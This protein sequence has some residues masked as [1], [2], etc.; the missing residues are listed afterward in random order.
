M[1]QRNLVLF[2]FQ[3]GA[4]GEMSFN[5]TTMSRPGVGSA[6]GGYAGANDMA[7]NGLSANQN[8]VSLNN[9]FLSSII[10]KSATITSESTVHRVV[11]LHL[12]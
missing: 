9:T 4:R 12:D 3:S 1:C 6:A 11:K 7:N 2:L 8:Q 10:C 5:A